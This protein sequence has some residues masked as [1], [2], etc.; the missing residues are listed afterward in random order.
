MDTHTS[1]TDR[2]AEARDVYARDRGAGHGTTVVA[3]IALIV[4]ALAMILSWMAYNRTGEDLEQK[5][6]DAVNASV[7]EAQPAAQDATDAT[8]EGVQ[9]AGEALDAGPDGVDE[10]DTDTMRTQ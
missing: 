10:D 3:W 6:Q 2:T 9:D 1:T 7:Q 4:A 5:I 8:T